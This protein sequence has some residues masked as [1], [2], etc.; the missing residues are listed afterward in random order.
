ML[1]YINCVKTIAWNIVE[2]SKQVNKNKGSI[3]L[4][5]IDEMNES[6]SG[7]QYFHLSS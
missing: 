6:V 7:L 1:P 4:K 5:F 3:N 2:L